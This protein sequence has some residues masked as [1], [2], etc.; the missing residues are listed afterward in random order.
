[1]P[2][3]QPFTA[4]ALTVSTTEI[5]LVS[6]TTTLQTNS[7]AGI[8][9]LFLDTNTLTAT[10]SYALK[11]KEK[12]GAAGTQRILQSILLTGVQ[13]TPVYVSAAMQLMNGWDITLT[14]LSGTDRAFDYSIR[15][16]S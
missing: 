8:Y 14:K 2:L 3:S 7:T 6:G 16:V 12:V 4:L 15:Q 10:E 11:I 9:Q 1:M 13:A 5:S